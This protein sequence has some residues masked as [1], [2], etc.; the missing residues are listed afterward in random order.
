M[1]AG[2]TAPSSSS[3]GRTSC[4]CTE[5]RAYNAFPL[6]IGI[7]L[8]TMNNLSSSRNGCIIFQWSYSDDKCLICL[9]DIRLPLTT[10]CGHR[11]CAECLIKWLEGPA[12][13]PT[14][15]C[16]TCRQHVSAL[17]R[18]FEPVENDEAC[19][20]L[21]RQINYYNRR[22]SG[23]PRPVSSAACASESAE[24]YTHTFTDFG[25]LST[26]PCPCVHLSN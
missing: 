20:Q 22:Y 7:A 9:E 4:G 23:E 16:P 26:L 14:T 17:L 5:K 21:L 12:R 11:F 6:S 3:C 19:Q 25:V 13:A 2:S 1:V 24:E 8:T 10:N 18:N 15:S